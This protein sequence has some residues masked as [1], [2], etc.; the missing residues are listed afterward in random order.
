MRRK[1]LKV[2]AGLILGLIVAVLA[3]W[4]YVGYASTKGI[5]TP[6]YTVVAEGKGYEVRAYAPY[7][8]AEVTLKGGYRDTLYGGFR[9]VADYIFGNNTRRT[10]VAMTAPV[11]SEPAPSENIAMTAPVL[12]E[13][14]GDAYTISFIM[15]SSYTLDTLPQPN[16]DQ[17]KL[18]AV[19]ETR[20][21]VASFGGYATESRCADKTARLQEQLRADGLVAAGPPI[22]AQ[23]D[24][25]WTPPY[26][27]RNEIQIP[28]ADP[29]SAG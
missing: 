5:E 29:P 4:T 18:H 25:P 2:L 22:V 11:L 8:R 21:A 7:I 3:G 13:P 23:Y 20:F 16:N 15:P 10:E 27:R 1:I 6:A 17:V 9:K 28:L 12:S 19:P 14:A 24:P 26:M